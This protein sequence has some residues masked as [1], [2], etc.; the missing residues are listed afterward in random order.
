MPVSAISL[1]LPVARQRL[2]RRIADAVAPGLRVDLVGGTAS[3]MGKLPPHARAL[4][5]LGYVVPVEKFTAADSPEGRERGL[6]FDELTAVFGEGAT[7]WQVFAIT[8]KGREALAAL[9]Q[10][11]AADEERHRLLAEGRVRREPG[12]IALADFDEEHHKVFDLRTGNVGKAIYIAIAR[13]LVHRPVLDPKY[14]FLLHFN[15]SPAGIAKR[16]AAGYFVGA[17]A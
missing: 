6:Q 10:R 4:L 16:L 1:E 8:D 7:T 9:E 14:P 2:L 11:N 12:V 15:L 5:Q 17:D 3:K 13:G